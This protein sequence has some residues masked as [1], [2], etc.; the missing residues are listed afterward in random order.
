MSDLPAPVESYIKRVEGGFQDDPR[1]RGNWTSGTIGEGE[2]RGT[3]YGISAAANPD[4]DIKNLT[5]AEADDI[6]VERYW[7]PSGAAERW[8]QGLLALALV[9]MDGSLHSGVSRGRIWASESEGDVLVAI[10]LRLD[11]LTSL[12][13]LWGDYGRGWTRRIA[14]LSLTAADLE[15][16]PSPEVGAPV[17]DMLVDNRTFISRLMSALSGQAGPTRYRVRTLHRGG[18][19]KLDINDA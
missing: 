2:L 5:W 17:V 7:I 12:T 4:L 8:D 16:Q 1:D 11:Y 9:I 15:E 14:D 18:G 13:N 19:T 6:Y 10:A 3:K